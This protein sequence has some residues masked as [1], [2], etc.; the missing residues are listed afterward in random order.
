MIIDRAAFSL[1][2]K[3]RADTLNIL[4]C[5]LNKLNW[6]F[7]TGFAYLKVLNIENSNNFP[8]TFYT[9]PSASLVSLSYLTL[10]TLSDMDK[11]YFTNIKYPPPLKNGLKSLSIEGIVY[12]NVLVDVSIQNF[13][14]KWITPSS[15]KTLIGLLLDNNNLLKIPS[16]VAQYENL[17]GAYFFSNAQPWVIQTNAFNFSKNTSYQRTLRIDN[18]RIKSIQPGAFQGLVY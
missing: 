7:L 2:T 14:A 6:G 16:E 18:S 13:L 4:N 11:F 15:R 8:D 5:D 9:F 12:P 17:T 10:K 1:L 3:I